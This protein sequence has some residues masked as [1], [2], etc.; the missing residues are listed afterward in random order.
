MD[1]NLFC[2]DNNLPYPVDT[3]Q[4]NGIPVFVWPA[5]VYF[6]SHYIRHAT[7]P[8]IVIWGEKK[9]W[10]V[11]GWKTTKTTAFEAL[12]CRTD[13]KFYDDRRGKKRRGA[14]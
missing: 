4:Y 11:D 2:R 6:D 10:Y 7:P 8:V 13:Q 12:K 1:I 14:R 3:A 5:W 9:T